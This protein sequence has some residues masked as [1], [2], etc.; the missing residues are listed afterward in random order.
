MS[1]SRQGPPRPWDDPLSPAVQ[2]GGSDA[3]R[4]AGLDHA[5]HSVGASAAPAAWEW[6]TEVGRVGLDV[7]ETEG[8]VRVAL[9]S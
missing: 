1:S 5:Q 2:E 6:G 4:G 7:P 9:S 8:P 3:A